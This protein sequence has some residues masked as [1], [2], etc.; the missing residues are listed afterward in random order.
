MIRSVLTRVAL[1]LAGTFAL[2]VAVPAYACDCDRKQADK[3]EKK[4]PTPVPARAQPALA[5]EKKAAT[6]DKAKVSASTPDRTL[7]EWQF[8]PSV[9]GQVRDD[10]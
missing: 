2:S 5:P 1:G 9:P 7:L 6:T 10:C 3:I 8:W 4:A